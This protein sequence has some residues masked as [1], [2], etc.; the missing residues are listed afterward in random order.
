MGTGPSGY[1]FGNG[2]AMF[3]DETGQ[4][5]N[6]LQKHGLSGVHLFREKF[7]DAPVF[8]AS[9]ETGFT[10]EVHPDVFD[11]ITQPEE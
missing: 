8:W 1:L 4:Q 9:F 11:H 7:P 6:E 5:M 10:D 2:N 3:F